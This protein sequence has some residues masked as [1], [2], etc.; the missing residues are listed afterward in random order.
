MAIINLNHS[1]GVCPIF[2]EGGLADR[3][4]AEA[5]KFLKSKTST[6]IV[7]DRNIAKY[8]LSKVRKSLERVGFKV[9]VT[10]LPAGEGQK[11]INNLKELYDVFLESKLDR[12]S[13]V[14]ALGGGVI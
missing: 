2:I 10:I 9:G 7:T 1:A 12:W 13:P 3:I 14:F 6:V 8:T 11:N 4:G 5:A